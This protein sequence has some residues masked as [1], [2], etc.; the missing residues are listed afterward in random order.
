[1]KKTLNIITIIFISCSF[2]SC[3]NDSEKNS[4]NTKETPQI[5][6][7][8]TVDGTFNSDI[9]RPTFTGLATSYNTISNPENEQISIKSIT[10]SKLECNDENVNLCDELLSYFNNSTEF[11][12][13]AE[14]EFATSD[15]NRKNVFR[16]KGSFNSGDKKVNATLY[17]SVHENDFKGDMIINTPS[18]IINTK[19]KIISIAVKGKK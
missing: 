1:M 18:E 17:F 16:I 6:S 19:E 13:L 12:F 14:E 8:Q 4:T 3:V 9:K 11:N 5:I 7:P 2:T 10:M 15:N